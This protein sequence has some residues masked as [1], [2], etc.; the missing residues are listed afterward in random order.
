MM[1]LMPEGG[2][3]L[4]LTSHTMMTTACRKKQSLNPGRLWLIQ[5]KREKAIGPTKL[6]NYLDEI[7]EDDRRELHG[8]IFAAACDFS[9]KARDAFREKIRE[10]G[11]QEGFLWGKGEIED[12]LFQ[13]KNDRLLFAYTGISL[14]VRRRSLSTELRSKLAMKRKAVRL[15]QP[16]SEILIRDP[17]DERY[18]RLD[19]S[20]K[21]RFDRGR[22]MV[23]KFEDFYHDGL[24]IQSWLCDAFIDDDGAHWDFAETV[25]NARPGPDFD[26]WEPRTWEEWNQEREKIFNI[27]AGLGER[28][29]ALYEL[30]HILPYE[31]ILDIDE[32]GDEIFDRP[33][34]YTVPFDPHFGP[35]LSGAYGS[36]HTI[37]GERRDADASNE[38]RVKIFPR[39]PDQ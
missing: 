26:P 19:K 32:K 9:K 30:I 17:T 24:H 35:F 12:M 23:V 31:N 39:L 22:W 20:K 29:Q 11:I 3:W 18:P 5:C 13:P 14:Q 8:I 6:K 10:F 2:K 16:G 27:F 33:H 36:L 34:V 37:H 15:L 4:P 21:S 25:N 1:V 38:T 28:N 7:S